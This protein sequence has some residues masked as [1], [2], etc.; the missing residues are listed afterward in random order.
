MQSRAWEVG[1]SAVVWMEI[2]IRGRLRAPTNWE[3]LKSNGKMVALDCIS[4]IAAF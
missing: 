3:V 4:M 2:W 1:G